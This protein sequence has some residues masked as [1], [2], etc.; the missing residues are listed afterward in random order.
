MCQDRIRDLGEVEGGRRAVGPSLDITLSTLRTPVE[1]K[2]VGIGVRPR[3]STEVSAE[4]EARARA[5]Y[6]QTDA[7]IVPVAS[8]PVAG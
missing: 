1:R 7:D 4:L 6:V 2:E 3:V 5:E 8:P